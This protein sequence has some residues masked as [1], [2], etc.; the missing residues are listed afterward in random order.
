MAE[1]FA[2]RTERLTQHA[3]GTL[4]LPAGKDDWIYWDPFPGYGLRLRAGGSRTLIFW[5]RIGRQ[6]R[7]MVI[8]SAEA[9]TATEGRKRAEILFAEVKLGRDPAGAKA[10]SRARTAETVGAVLPLYLARQKERLRPRAYVEVERHLN[11]HAK[12]LHRQPLVNVTRRDIAGVLT[13]IAATKSNAT[14]NRVRSSLSAFAGWCIREGLLDSSPV[15]WTE[16]RPETSRSRLIAPEEL[17]EIWA[18]LRADAYGDILKLLILC[19]ARRDEVGALRFSEI[20]FDEALILLPPARVKNRRARI[21][22]LSRPALAILQN[23][24][25][26]T[27][28]DGS[29]CDLVFGRGVRGFAD[30]VGSKVDLDARITARR[31]EP[32]PDWTP[33][34]FR[35]LLSTTMHEQLAV[36]PHIVETCLGHVGHQRGTPGIYNRA[37]YV[38]PMREALARWAEFVLA[39]VEGR[40]P[41]VVALRA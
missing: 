38:N 30:W 34:D 4:A 35:R 21:I 2:Q 23:R 7:K 8:G 22:V 19:G 29:P 40:D 10:E 5:Y 28:P 41:K 25:R 32:L 37:V 1:R 27:W 33:H 36:Q 6:R 12:R 26:L 24:P 17:R 13:T 39:V 20:D 31:G 18:S 3:I 14:A 9:V 16:R 15:A 11:I